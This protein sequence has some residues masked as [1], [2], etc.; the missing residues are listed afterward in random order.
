MLI[1]WNK[2][3]IEFVLTILQTYV[4][5]WNHKETSQLT[6]TLAES[7]VPLWYQGVNDVTWICTVT[8]S[9]GKRLLLK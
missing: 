2:Y 7:L 6:T 4:L 1:L 3:F 5:V 9:V 8:L